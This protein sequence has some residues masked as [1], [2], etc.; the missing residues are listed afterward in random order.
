MCFCC[1]N[2]I[3]AL[4]AQQAKILLGE[5][6]L[7]Q[8]IITSN[9]PE[10]HPASSFLLKARTETCLLNQQKRKILPQNKAF[11]A[12]RAAAYLVVLVGGDGDEGGLGEDVGAE[13]RV[14]G[15]ERVVLVRLHN[16]QPG[17]V[18]VH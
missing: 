5:P 16:V 17:L 8:N 15:A 6:R 3:S 9:I 12:P 1:L 2:D 4:R 7:C 14:L 13:C 18:F 11:V 10:L